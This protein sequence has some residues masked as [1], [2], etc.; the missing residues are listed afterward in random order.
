MTYYI[1]DFLEVLGEGGLRASE[2]T[3]PL[4]VVKPKGMKNNKLG[5]GS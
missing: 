2:M 5:G 3:S 4:R 1:K